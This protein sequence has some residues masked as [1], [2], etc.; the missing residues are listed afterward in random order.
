M[1]KKINVAELLKGCPKD[2]ELDC[3]M[4]ENVTFVGVDMSRKQFPLEIAVGGTRTKYL[5]KEGCFHDTILLPEAKC[6]IFPKGRT[7]WQGFQSPFKDGDVISDGAFI[8]IFHKLDNGHMYYR[9]WYNSELNEFEAKIDFGIG[10]I[11]D[12]KYADKEEKQKLFDAIKERGY[13]WIAETKTLEKLPKFKV[14]DRVKHTSAY[15]SGIVVKVS[16]KGYHIDYPKGEGI[17]YISFALEKDYELAPNKFDITTLRGFES[18]VLVRDYDNRMWTPT[19]WGKYLEDDSNCRYL[20]TNGC[21]KYCIP[22]EG[23]EHLSGTTN[24]CDEFFKTW[25]N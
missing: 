9:C 13:R 21:Y 11:E 25:K 14:G 3:T 24:D 7:T 20:T 1:E 16:D 22:Y 5:T 15:V 2:M 8:A 4:F 12:Y 10:Y 6:V 18:R 17:C 19:F 23:N